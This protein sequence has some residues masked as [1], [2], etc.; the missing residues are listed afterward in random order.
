MYKKNKTLIKFVNNTGWILFKEVYAML[1]S[2]IVGSLSARYLGPSNY[3]IISYGSSL[4]SFFLIVTQLGMSN[5]IILEIVRK[6]QHISSYLGSAVYM[7]FVVSVIS[8]C[9]IQGIIVCLE[10]DNILLHRVTFLQSVSL[11]FQTS[12][13]LFCWFHAKMEMKYVTLAG[14]TALT[15]TSVWRVVL[16]AKKASIEWFALSLSI[17]AL[18]SCIMICVFFF[19]RAKVRLKFNFSV[20]VSILANSY[21]FIINSVALTFYTQIDKIMIGKALDETVLGYYTAASAISVMW[22]VIPNAILN[23]AR[24]LF[25]QKYDIDKKEFVRR[26]QLVILGISVIGI[27]VGFGF[28]IF[29]KLFVWI[30]YGSDYYAAVPALKILAWATVCST[31][32]SARTTWMVLNN[33]SKYMEYFTLIGAA[34]NITLNLIFIYFWGYIGAALATLITSLFTGIILP[35]LFRETR[36]YIQIFVGSFRQVPSFIELF[37]KKLMIKNK[38][39]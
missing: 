22:E 6:P 9:L 18:I 17:S 23:S 21:H 26:Y 37:L 10:P 32:G 1:V 8:V 4:I 34:I 36:E 11:I 33:K 13:V 39:R 29:A 25:V 27:F 38:K 16:L 35:F 7:R 15:V 12:D 31:I 19:A 5:V 28:T 14:I 30:L 3:G 24:P 2:L 20:A